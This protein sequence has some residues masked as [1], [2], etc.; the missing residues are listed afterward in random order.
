MKKTYIESFHSILERECYQRNCFETHEEAFVE[1]DR[2][3]RYYNNHRIHGCLIIR[4]KNI[5][6]WLRKDS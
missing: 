3:L 4:Q 5:F 1:V 2:F 6:L